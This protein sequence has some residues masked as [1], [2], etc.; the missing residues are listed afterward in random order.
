MSTLFLPYQQGFRLR[1]NR[2]LSNLYISDLLLHISDR[3]YQVPGVLH[4][5]TFSMY[6]P[7]LHHTFWRFLLYSILEVPRNVFHSTAMTH[8]T[9]LMRGPSPVE[10]SIAYVWLV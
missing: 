1:E 5:W 6:E 8:I 10:R 9:E 7:V 3:F 2:P 4:P